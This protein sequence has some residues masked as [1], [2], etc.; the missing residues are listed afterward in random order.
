MPG[1]DHRRRPPE[2]RAGV[3]ALLRQRRGERHA[4]RSGDRSRSSWTSTGALR[5]RPR[6]AAAA[7]RERVSRIPR[8]VPADRPD[9][10][11]LPRASRELLHRSVGRGLSVHHLLEADRPPARH[12]DAAGSDLERARDQADCSARSGRGSARSAG[13]PARRIRASSATCWPAAAAAAAAAR[14]AAVARPRRRHPSA[15]DERHLLHR[16][17]RSRPTWTRRSRTTSRPTCRP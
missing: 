12:R 16:R 15:R 10:D 13:P 1:P 8:R 6:S 9:A 11:A 7:A 4:R 2:R 5:G 3:G 14:A 17:G